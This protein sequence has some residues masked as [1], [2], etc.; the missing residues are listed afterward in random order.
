VCAGAKG[1]PRWGPKQLASSGLD[2]NP[3]IAIAAKVLV[4]SKSLLKQKGSPNQ[5][6]DDANTPHNTYLFPVDCYK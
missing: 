3:L 6:L 4:Q 2:S 5:C 1:G